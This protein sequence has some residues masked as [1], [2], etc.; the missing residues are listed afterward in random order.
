MG[1]R[2]W[3]IQKA[4]EV[5]P[6]IKEEAIANLCPEIAIGIPPRLMGIID[7]A[8]LPIAFEEPDA[9]EGHPPLCTHWARIDSFNV[10]EMKPVKV[11]RTWNGKEYTVNCYI[12]ESIKDQY[13]A[14]DIVIDDYVLVEFLEDSADKAVVFAKVLKTW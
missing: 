14:G 5:T 9:L 12:T 8:S 13:L 4:I 1:R 10:A 6:D 3:I 11:K 7:E 2:I